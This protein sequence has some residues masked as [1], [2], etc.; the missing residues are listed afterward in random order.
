M[1]LFAIA[2]ICSFLHQACAS[3][4]NYKL[5]NKKCRKDKAQ[6]KKLLPTN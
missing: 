4:V 5:M 2:L 1:T 6:I 3:S